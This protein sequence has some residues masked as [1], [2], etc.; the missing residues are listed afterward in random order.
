MAIAKVELNDLIKYK[1]EIEQLIEVLRETQ[2]G[3]DELEK[4]DNDIKKEI[5]EYEDASRKCDQ[6]ISELMISLDSLRIRNVNW[7][8]KYAC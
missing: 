7:S 3:I 5:G 2:G 4:T 8:K 6:I 1:E